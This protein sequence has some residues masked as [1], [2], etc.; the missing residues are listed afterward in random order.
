MGY[1]RKL[2]AIR[3]ALGL[4]Q[5][6]VASHTQVQQATISAIET[7]DSTRS[8]HI[9]TLAR[10]YGLSMDD[11]VAHDVDTL[12]AKALAQHGAPAAPAPL[13]AV[14]LIGADSHAREVKAPPAPYE[15]PR[16]IETELLRLLGEL[17]PEQ[18]TLLLKEVEGTV[19][20][21]RTIAQHYAARGATNSKGPR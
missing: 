17:T 9:P 16:D 21:N 1:G 7:R 10:H 20:A 13:P 5:P 2:K 4:T 8:E 11:L 19:A 14:G 12:V 18:R 3:E 15:V 6:E